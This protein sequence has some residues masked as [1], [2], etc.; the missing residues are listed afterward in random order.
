M[1]HSDFLAPSLP[2]RHY[3]ILVAI[4]RRDFRGTDQLHTVSECTNGDIPQNE[5][6]FRVQPVWA[7]DYFL[8]LGLPDG[9]GTTYNSARTEF[10]PAD[11]VN[12]RADLTLTL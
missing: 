2:K 8:S 5:E 6:L 7:D 9:A 12:E 4:R 10:F 1:R 11:S 3:S